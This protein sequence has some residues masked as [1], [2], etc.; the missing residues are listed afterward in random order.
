MLS[1]VVCSLFLT[2]VAGRNLRFFLT[3]HVC[4]LIAVSPLAFSSLQLFPF[5]LLLSD[6]LLAQPFLSNG[7]VA[8]IAT[9]AYYFMYFFSDAK[10]KY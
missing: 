7:V 9:E 8:T 5:Q 3:V 10:V 2:S 4:V 1:V 6:P